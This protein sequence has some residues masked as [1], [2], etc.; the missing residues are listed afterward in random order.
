MKK[1]FFVNQ[2][3]GE[4]DIIPISSISCLAAMPFNLVPKD[5]EDK[6]K[7]YGLNICIAIPHENQEE[8][9]AFR[10][11]LAFDE[12]FEVWAESGWMRVSIWVHDGNAYEEGWGG[13]C[14]FGY[15]TPSAFDKPQ[16]PIDSEKIGFGKYP[17]VLGS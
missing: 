5:C 6:D 3:T 15:L 16:D 2:K 7:L 9:I 11:K 17:M 8:Y 12:L 13:S 10:E 4:R 1:M 14:L